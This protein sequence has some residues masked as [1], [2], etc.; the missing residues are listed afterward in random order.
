MT[1]R[2]PA[3]S[4]TTSDRSARA[5]RER[6]EPRLATRTQGRGIP[7]KFRNRIFGK[8]TQA[9]AGDAREKGGTGLGLSIVKATI[10]AMH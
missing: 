8:F 7:E 3:E 2:R 5:T 9:D 4:V 1:R 10:E 6:G